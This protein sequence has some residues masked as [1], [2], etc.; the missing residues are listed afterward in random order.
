MNLEDSTRMVVESVV[1]HFEALG[2]RVEHE[3]RGYGVD[4]LCFGEVTISSVRDPGAI[5]INDVVLMLDLFTSTG[6]HIVYG[7]SE[8]SY[9]SPIRLEDPDFLVRLEE[10]VSFSA[11]RVRGL[12][13]K[14][15]GS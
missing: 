9:T 10:L 8:Y 11:K 7:A 12:R 14:C 2:F 13:G 15:G 1:E 5:G 6:I 3:I 4:G